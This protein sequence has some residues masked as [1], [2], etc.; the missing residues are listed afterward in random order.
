MTDKPEAVAWMYEWPDGFAQTDIG[1]ERYSPSYVERYGLTEIPLYPE[2][3]SQPDA[4]ALVAA[5]KGMVRALDM[6]SGMP[7]EDRVTVWLSASAA[8][9]AALQS[10]EAQH[11]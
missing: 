10:W 3:P 9:R 4:S 11:G 2:P 7:V 1:P 5:L 8:A 6:T